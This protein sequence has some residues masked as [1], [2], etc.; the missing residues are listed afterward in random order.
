MSTYY[1]LDPVSDSEFIVSPEDAGVR[2]D[3]FLAAPARVG[4]RAR[5][6]AA[7]D[8]GKV[9]V[10]G[11]QAGLFQASTRLAGGDIVRVWMDRP[12]SAKPR[13]VS[14]QIGDLQVVYEDEA[15]LVVNKPAGL[16]SVPLERR[17]DLPSVSDQIEDHFRSRGKRRPLVVHRIDQDTSGLV[18]FA[19]DAQTQ[20][21]LKAQFKRREPERVYWAVV[22]GQPSPPEGTWRDHLVWDEKALIQKETHPRDPRANEAISEYRTLEAFRD[23][24][25]IEVRLRTGRRNQIRIQARLRGHTL[26]GEQRYVLSPGTL[27][28]INF[29]RQALHAYRLAFQHPDDGRRLEFEAP[30]PPDLMSLLKRLRRE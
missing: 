30:L 26:V 8:R 28:P 16:L 9:F 24:S 19:K 21:R 4:S 14:S 1:G 11:Q 18:V 22:Y 17:S 10:N 2:L 15:L 5:A 13:R 29:E 25:L 7:L 20:S 27:R 3:K 23:A 12:G 6:V